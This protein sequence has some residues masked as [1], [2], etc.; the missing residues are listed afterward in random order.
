MSKADALRKEANEAV[1]IGDRAIE[2]LRYIRETIESSKSFTAVPGYGGILMGATALPAAWFASSQ[3][4]I[5]EW[6]AVW[7]VEAVLA[8]TIGLFAMWQ[9]SK[10]SGLSLL[11]GPARKLLVN[12]FPPIFCAILITFGLWRYSQ[13]E[14]MIPVWIV[15]YGAA[16]VC[17]GAFSVKPVPVMG[18]CFLVVGAI[19]FF[20]PAGFGNIMMAASFGILHMAFGFII[21]RRYGG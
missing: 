11:T 6:L 3:T 13:F 1:N 4:S 5:R 20:M 18:W 21:G 10:I 14:L 9:K 2:N 16:V 19:S 17:G 15:C 8:G 12:S 7:L